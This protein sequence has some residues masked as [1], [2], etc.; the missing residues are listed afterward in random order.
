MAMEGRMIRFTNRFMRDESGATAIEYG[1][2]LAMMFLTILAAV[3][4]FADNSTK[5]FNDASTA[6]VA[7]GS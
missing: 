5:K 3:T 2:L 1:L 6:I 7:A 4:L